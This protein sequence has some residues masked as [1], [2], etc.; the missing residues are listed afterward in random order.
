MGEEIKT[1]M[2]TKEKAG[3]KELDEKEEEDKEKKSLG[4][5]G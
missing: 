5:L 2:E 3:E 4:A 1:G